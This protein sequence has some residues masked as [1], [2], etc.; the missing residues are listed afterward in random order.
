MRRFNSRHEDIED[1]LQETL[2]SAYRA[3][4]DGNYKYVGVAAFVG[5]LR[6]IARHAM[7]QRVSAEVYLLPLSFKDQSG[8]E[9][10]IDLPA[11]GCDPAQRAEYSQL[12]EFLEQQLDEVLIK[13]ETAHEDRDIGLLKKMAFL[14]FYVDQLTQ[15]EVANAACKDAA[16][17][18]LVAQIS[19][20]TINNWT[21]RG[22]ILRLL[23][24]HLVDE[25]PEAISRVMQLSIVG[26]LDSDECEALRAHWGLGRS[27]GDIAENQNLLPS[28]MEGALTTAK[29]KLAAALFARIKSDLHDLRLKN[30]K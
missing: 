5:W 18:G 15:R 2:V 26:L 3:M 20:T 7:I 13:R 22:D 9:V 19:Q 14:R 1:S 28:G 24:R 8:R 11:G 10:P 16:Q 23:I 4:R 29:R 6:T 27:S 30:E 21:A 17:L 12:F 25:H